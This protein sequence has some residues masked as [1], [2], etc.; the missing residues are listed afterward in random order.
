MS[1]VEP[2]L[3]AKPPRRVRPV[4]EPIDASG[5]LAFESRHGEA[6][7]MSLTRHPFLELLLIT[8]GGGVIQGD[9]GRRRCG[10]GD[11]VVLPPGMRHRIVD[12]PRQPISL[13]GLGIAQR[14]LASVPGSVGAIPEG[15]VPADTL[16]PLRL[17]HRMRR[18]LYTHGRGDPASRMAALAASLDLLS[19][20][21]LATG[22]PADRRRLAGSADLSRE[23][24]AAV[25]E[26]DPMLESYLVWLQHN[27]FESQSL[28]D[29]VLACGMSRRSFTTAFRHRTG[30]TWL[31]YLNRLRV[32]HAIELLQTTDRKMTSIAFRCGFDDL[33][34]FYRAF[35]RITG[36]RPGQWRR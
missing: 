6:F 8:A 25:G 5:I 23:G 26:A 19:Q 4:D 27:F 2:P 34:T 16:G 15:I 7:Q 9:W 21:M 35:H 17:E 36:K 32:E 31:E 14:W 11:L 33:S 28:D 22:P 29:A 3:E 10:R 30:Q 1:A 18:L 13:Y 24:A 12:H 20:V